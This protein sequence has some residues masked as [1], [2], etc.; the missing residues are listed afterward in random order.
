MTRP[1]RDLV[2]LRLARELATLAT[3]PR[4]QVGCLFVDAFNRII[5]SGY[6]GV[7]AGAAHCTEQ[8]CPGARF[9]PGT[10]LAACQ[11]I[12]AEMNA[13]ALCGDVKA[14]AKIYVTASPCSA[15]VKV[16]LT[17]SARQLVFSELYPGA[18]E[19][20]EI[21]VGAGRNFLYLPDAKEPG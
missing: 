21:W 20:L 16:L 5:S 19:T 1:S 13:L 18:E 7:P 10:G 14:V 2:F 4:R 15:C 12:H 11:A 6:N 9:L 3:C 8:P 17:T